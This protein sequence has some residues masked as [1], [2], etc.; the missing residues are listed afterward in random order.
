MKLY[1]IDLAGHN[2]PDRAF[3]SK[4]EAVKAARAALKAECEEERE[5]A[6]E[7]AE[8]TSDNWLNDGDDYLA[9]AVANKK[10]KAK[11]LRPEPFGPA[12]LQ[13]LDLPATKAGLILAYE[14]GFGDGQTHGKSI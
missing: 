6:L 2:V 11:A 9:S 10:G 8:Y 1:I 13:C 7:E 3:S 4:Q 5:Q 12:D 14:S